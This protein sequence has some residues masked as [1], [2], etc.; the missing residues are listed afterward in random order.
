MRKLDTY[1]D[2]AIKAITPIKFYECGICH[3][4][5]GSNEIPGSIQALFTHYEHCNTD[6]VIPYSY[7]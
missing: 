1:N 7:E 4:Q 2:G 6:P 3:Q 5:V